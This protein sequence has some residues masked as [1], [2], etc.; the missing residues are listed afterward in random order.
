MEL[1]KHSLEKW[2]LSPALV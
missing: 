1:W 2:R